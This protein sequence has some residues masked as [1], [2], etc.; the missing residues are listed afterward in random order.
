MRSKALILITC[1]LLLC[2]STIAQTLAYMFDWE[3]K[4]NTFTVGNVRISL[5]ESTGKENDYGEREHDML[6]GATAV[7]KD[8]KVTILGGSE[9][10][11]LF[12]RLEKSANFDEYLQYTKS[13]LTEQGFFEDWGVLSEDMVNDPND[14]VTVLY[15]KVPATDEN[16]EYY[17]LD[18]NQVEIIATE[19]ALGELNYNNQANAPSLSISAYAIQQNGLGGDPETVWTMIPGL[20]KVPANTPVVISET[21]AETSTPTETSEPTETSAPVETSEPEETSEPTETS[22]PEETSEPTETSEP[23]E[24]SDPTETSETSEDPEEL[25]KPAESSQL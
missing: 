17:I 12:V 5:E 13:S 7:S 4:V 10:C 21:P 1:L 23:E 18:K 14:L 11:W 3:E 16:V 9:D 15:T 8:P 24:T 25:D 22:E 2:G 6:E 20:T 19:E